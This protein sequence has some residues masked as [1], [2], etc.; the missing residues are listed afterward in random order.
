M[1]YDTNDLNN[2][3]ILDL[4]YKLGLQLNRSNKCVCFI[5]EEKEPSLQFYDKTNTWYCFG[6]GKGGNVIT[7]VQNFTG[8]DFKTACQWLHETYNLSF[9]PTINNKKPIQKVSKKGEDNLY[10][11]YDLE[12]NNWVINNSYLDTQGY[13][14]LTM[15]RGLSIKIINKYKICSLNNLEIFYNL[16]KH[17]SIDRLITA[18]YYKIDK[19]GEV[20]PIWWSNG[21]LRKQKS[22]EQRIKRS[23]KVY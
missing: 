11:F 4:A 12:I 14:Y 17:F 19:N 6:C 2:I 1:Y 18:G 16:E 9:N 3:N 15:E 7:F 22:K 20:K 8:C 5:H 10:K 21:I 23:R 13:Q